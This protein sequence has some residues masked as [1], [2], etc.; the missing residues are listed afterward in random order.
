MLLTVVIASSYKTTEAITVY[1][2]RILESTT[3]DGYIDEHNSNYTLARNDAV[4]IAI[5]SITYG[6]CGQYPNNTGIFTVTRTFLYFDTS[7]IPTDANYSSAILSIYIENEQSVIDFNVT[8]QSGQPTYPHDPMVGADFLYTHYSGNGGSRNTSTI[9]GEVY[10]NITLNSQGIGWINE[11]GTTKLCLRS[12][13][14][15]NAIMPDDTNNEFITHYMVEKG[16]GYVPKL[17][18][19]YSTDSAFLYRLYGAYNEDG[20]RDGAINITFYRPEE[21]PLSFEL[22]GQYNATSEADTRM[23]FHFDLGYNQSRVYY[24][25]D[26]YEDIYVFKPSEPYTTYTFSVIDYVGITNGYLESLI[27]VNGTNRIVERWSLS[28]LN[29]IPFT[30]SWARS[31]DIRLVCDEGTYT[32][33]GFVALEDTTQTI[34]IMPGM[35]P[36]TYPGLIVSAN[37]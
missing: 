32:W 3:S 37:E 13:R 27:N 7:M 21:V 14:D 28:M 10:W 25:K 2:T 34:V 18:V 17:Y 33:A 5:D 22:D 26:T 29:D 31:Y 8:I 23:V 19:S 16:A 12:S 4:G 35:F 9:P 30:M 36:I 24:V 11:G 15:I 6:T 1:T 20:D